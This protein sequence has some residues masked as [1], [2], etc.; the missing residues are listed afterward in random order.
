MATATPSRPS[1][2]LRPLRTSYTVGARRDSRPAAHGIVGFR[3]LDGRDLGLSCRGGGRDVPGLAERRGGGDAVL[4]RPGGDPRGPGGGAGY[5]PRAGR[6]RAGGAALRPAART[7]RGRALLR[8][9]GG[10]A[11]GAG[12][13]R[14]PARGAG[15]AG[16][17]PPDA[18][19]GTP[20]PRVC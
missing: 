6:E 3:R 20:P 14:V 2:P 9:A 4:S 5:Q 15:A 16:V 13:G 11:V 17:Q 8:A 7:G 1:A 18:G 12:R 19:G 10:G